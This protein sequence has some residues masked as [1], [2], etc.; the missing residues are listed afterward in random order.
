[1]YLK[2]GRK[3]RERYIY[4]SFLERKKGK[5]KI[6]KKYIKKIQKETS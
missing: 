3:I 5:K 4:I 2:S 6:F 1:M